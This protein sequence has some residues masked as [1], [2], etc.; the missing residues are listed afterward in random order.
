MKIQL[1]H[2]ESESIFFD[3]LCNGLNELCYYD[4]DVR[5]DE[6]AYMEAREK[7]ES[8]C[9]EDVLMQ[10]L[11][12]GKYIYLHDLNDEDEVHAINLD[13]VH[14]NVEKAP[15]RHLMDAINEDGD[16]TTADVILQTVFLG[17]VIFG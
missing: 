13:K 3:A 15:L 9:F 5:Y 8:P 16:A 10:M 11:R 4:L 7:L 14:E 17:E 6:D 1:T 2:Q 12:D